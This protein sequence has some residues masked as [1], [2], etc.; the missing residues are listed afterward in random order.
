MQLSFNQHLTKLQNLPREE[1]RQ[2]YQ[3]TFESK[4]AKLI[5][6]DLANISGMYRTNFVSNGNDGADNSYRTVFLEGQRALFLYICS[7]LEEN[8]DNNIEGKI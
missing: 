7:Q 5:L 8:I 4:D 1:L 6:E 3:R 2:I